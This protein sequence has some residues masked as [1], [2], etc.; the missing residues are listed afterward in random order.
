MAALLPRLARSAQ[1]GDPGA[2]RDDLSQG[3]RNSAVAIVPIAFG[4]LALGIPMCTLIY[5]SS[6]IDSATSMGYMLMAFGLGLIPFSV[7]YVVLRGFYAYEDTRTPFYN[8]VIVAA[9]NAA[10]SAL[11]FLVLPARWAVVGMAAS[12]GL[13]YVIGVGVAWRRLRRTLGGDLDGAHV[14]RTYAR[15]AGASVPAALAAAGTAYG[16]TRLLG[17]GVTGSLAA[18][19]AGG[20]VLAVVFVLAA[21]RMRIA[22]MNALIGMV[23]AKIGR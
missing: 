5:G 20:L 18:L 14:V 15:L 7:Q 3:L 17:M 11:C 21:K 8:T 2:V 16:V 10:A 6:G 12:Y 9:V 19:A 23:R 4:F 1:D 13:A 22:E